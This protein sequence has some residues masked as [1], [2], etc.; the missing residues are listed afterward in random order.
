MYDFNI[1]NLAIPGIILLSLC[2]FFLG[3]GG[4]DLAAP[5]EPQY[6]L[7]AREMLKDNHWVLP[8][9]NDNPYPD[10]PPFFFWTIASFSAL[11]GGK[12]NAWTA[13]LPSAVSAAIILFLMWRW[14]K[15]ESDENSSFIQTL[16]ALVL[17]SCF[18]FFFQARIAQID[19]VLC[20]FTT[21][22][23]L[24]GFKAICNQKFSA[25]RLGIWM[26]AGM[27]TK[28]PVGYI[29]PAGIM[30]LFS[31]FKGRSFWKNYPIKALVWGLLPVALWL[32]LLFI[33]VTIHGQWDY[34]KNI[35][36]KQT[37]VRFFNPWHHH[38]PFYY[39]FVS[40][41]YDF[42]PW[43]PF[44]LI[45][46]PFNKTKLRALGTKEQYSW[47]VII[48]TLVFF[49][50]S[51]GK[52]S[53]YILPVF[54]FASYL[55]A[56]KINKMIM[57]QRLDKLEIGSG[58]F[59]GILL[60]ISGAAIIAISAGRVKLPFNWIDTSP[61]VSWI[62]ISGLILAAI[63]IFIIF[64]FIKKN[65]KH[66]VLGIV[67]SMLTINFLFYQAVLPWLEPY[68]S[69]RG[70]MEKANTIIHNNSEHPIIAIVDFRAAF[71]L[72]GDFP[73]VEL[74]NEN[75]IPDQNLPKLKYFFEKYP[76]GW[77]IVREKDWI[78]FLKN[79]PFNGVIHLKQKIGEGENFIL[80]S[81]N[82]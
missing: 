56:F 64:S 50:L 45:S 15:P 13:R 17:M 60:F 68:R 33:D 26:G 1:K 75:G 67:F 53:I 77:V 37:I 24:T 28:G 19:M 54:P 42:L 58:L 74:A 76:D 66:A 36:F 82:A 49:S 55:T 79:N 70:F 81:K 35:L 61:P 25:F 71:R 4:Y 30:A 62:F 73:L 14:S 31:G 65:V 47:L 51:K 38:K 46:I 32:I 69:A 8:Y 48:F 63:S 52:R 59:S 39:F 23:L 16:T 22:A 11:L 44:L 78:M 29:I 9:R 5:D 72:Y 2:F 41:L 20:L 7:V 34:L 21:L 3:L 10:K 6:A 43:T 18:K 80:V 40:I 57:K 12:V 27:L